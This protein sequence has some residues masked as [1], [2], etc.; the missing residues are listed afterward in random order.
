MIVV[1]VPNAGAKRAEEYSPIAIVDNVAPAGSEFIAFLTGEA[2]PRV[3]RAFRVKTGPENTGIGGSSLGAVI[4]M[5]AA[6]EH[7]EVFGKV[8]CE[9]MPMTTHE[10]AVFKHFAA[11]KSWPRQIAMGMGGKE[12]GTD[13]KSEPQNRQLSAT[14]AAFKELMAG[15]GLASDRFRLT[16]EEGAPHDETAWA[17]RLGGELEFLFPAKK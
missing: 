12:F 10:R 11:K 5:E 14:A 1:G 13:E 8:I 3:Q 9:S 6:T 17:K 4:A 15:K 2:M 16:V 7:P